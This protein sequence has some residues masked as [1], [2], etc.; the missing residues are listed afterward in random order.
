MVYH[1]TE[2]GDP[3]P[4]PAFSELAG[5]EVHH[6]IQDAYQPGVCVPFPSVCYP[7]QG[8][9]YPQGSLQAGLIIRTQRPLSLL[10]PLSLV[11][12][13]L[14]LGI[15]ESG[16][17]QGQPHDSLVRVG[18][19]PLAVPDHPPVQP[20]VI[21]DVDPIQVPEQLGIPGLRAVILPSSATPCV[22]ELGQNQV[23]S[24]LAIVR[25]L[26]PLDPLQ[27]RLSEQPV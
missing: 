17:L 20:C 15:P 3:V 21:A 7:L 22:S 6:P 25:P 19:P 11:R 12:Y 14:G 24:P 5:S 2:P 9:G 23:Y 13:D 1:R 4:P 26:F 27:P 10:F 8:G 16:H 18:F